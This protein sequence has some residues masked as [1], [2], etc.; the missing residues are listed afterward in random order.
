MPGLPNANVGL[1]GEVIDGELLPAYVRNQRVYCAEAD[2]RIVALLY[3]EENFV[4]DPAFWFIHQIT[5]GTDWRRKG[6]ATGLMRAFLH[7]AASR[8]SKK[9]FADVRQ[10]NERSL[11]LMMK[12]GA[13]ESGWLKGLA[14]DS[15]DDIWRIF[16]FDFP[17]QDASGGR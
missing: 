9:V 1:L 16:R 11:G 10:N 7:H 12:L 5:V 6:V 8:G 4:G 17:D 13:T 3:W 2:D 14:D 15:P